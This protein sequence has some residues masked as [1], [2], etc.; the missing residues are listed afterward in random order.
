M[1]TSY[2]FHHPNPGT[3]VKVISLFMS[4]AKY[5]TGS[6]RFG[7]EWL[8]NILHSNLVGII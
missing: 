5:V 3:R 2:A 7:F 6:T 4:M 8:H 1:L